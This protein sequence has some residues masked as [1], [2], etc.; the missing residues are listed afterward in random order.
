MA[1]RIKECQI[2][3]LPDGAIWEMSLMVEGN[4]W[5]IYLRTYMKEAIMELLNHKMA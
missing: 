2:L 1:R 5:L 3:G 4:Y